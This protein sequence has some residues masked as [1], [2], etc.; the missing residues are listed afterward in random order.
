MKNALSL[1]LV[2]W[3]LSWCM[4]VWCEEKKL[5]PGVVNDWIR[6]TVTSET[7]DSELKRVVYSSTI[8]NWRSDRTFYHVR[9]EVKNSSCERNLI[10]NITDF[11]GNT[12]HSDW[13]KSIEEGREQKSLQINDPKI[14][15]RTFRNGKPKD[16]RPIMDLDVKYQVQDGSPVLVVSN[17]QDVIRTLREFKTGDSAHIRIGAF[18]RSS[19]FELDLNGF[20]DKE[21]WFNEHCP[22]KDTASNN[23]TESPAS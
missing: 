15:V 3:T 16:E 21:M 14:F 9:Y 10:F 5:D 1:T 2:I 23:T 13:V 20:A 17:Q 12:Y 22:L 18:D 8:A 11:H 19:T 4:N 7:D 6:A